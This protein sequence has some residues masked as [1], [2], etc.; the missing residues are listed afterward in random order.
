MRSI[1]RRYFVQFGG[2]VALAGL[3]GCGSVSPWSSADE[4][5][6]GEVTIEN[7]DTTPHEVTFR[8]EWA[9]TVV[10]DRSYTLAANDPTD[11]IV[12][13]VSP[14][15]TW[16]TKPGDFRV[17]ARLDEEEWQTATPAE[18]EYPDCYTVV[19]HIDTTGQMAILTTTNVHT[20]PQISDD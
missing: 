10:H 12:P 17:M 8:V 7:R 6:L 3:A 2:A 13:A 15:A 18:R 9:G 19:V 5:H 1:S 11:E 14:E 4:S 20:C 16:P